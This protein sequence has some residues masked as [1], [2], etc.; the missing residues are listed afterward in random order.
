MAGFYRAFAAAQAAKLA[1]AFRPRPGPRID[2]NL[3]YGLRIGGSVLFENEV[4]FVIAASAGHLVEKPKGGVAKIAAYGR[5][6][7]DGNWIHRCYLDAD[8]GEESFLQADH[9]PRR[10]AD[11]RR[12]AAL[13]A[14][15]GDHAGDAGGM[16]G[17]AAGRS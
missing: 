6:P 10:A 7:A 1:A 14:V 4:P 9:R 2:D 12:A 16:V 15:P 17:V 8:A 5:M 11:R 3:P 13:P